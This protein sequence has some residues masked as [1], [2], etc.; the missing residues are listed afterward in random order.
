MKTCSVVKLQVYR[1]KEYQQPTYRDWIEPDSVEAGQ[2]G[3]KVDPNPTFQLMKIS[4]K[5]GKIYIVYQK[6]K[7]KQGWIRSNNNQKMIL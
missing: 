5:P 6:K 7:K 4:S 1:V 2:Q 3:H